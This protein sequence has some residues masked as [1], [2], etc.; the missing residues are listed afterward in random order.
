MVYFWSSSVLCQLFLAPCHSLSFSQKNCFTILPFFLCCCDVAKLLWWSI[1]F[2]SRDETHIYS[3]M[4]GQHGASQDAKSRWYT[5]AI[6]FQFFVNRFKKTNP[7][8]SHNLDWLF[9]RFQAHEH[10]AHSHTCSCDS[11]PPETKCVQSSPSI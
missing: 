10:S 3:L 6:K 1:D 4:D 2:F 9:H 8:I 7:S 11:F 5:C